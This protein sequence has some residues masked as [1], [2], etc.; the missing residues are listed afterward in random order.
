M[1]I[2]VVEDERKL[3]TD[4][5][6]ALAGA[7]HV[8]EEAG[9]GEHAWF[10]GDTE[11]YDLII[12]DLGLPKLDGV[13]VLKRWRANQRTMPVLV[14]TARD[15]WSEKVEAID[16][17]ADDYL[18]KPFRMEELLARVRA[19]L[20]RQT[21]HSSAMLEVGEI[22][23]DTR[24]SRVTKAGT[25]VDLSPLEYRLLHYLMHH[26]GR[27]VSQIELTEHVYSQD[28]ERESNAIE[29][30]IGRL[31]RKLGAD[32]V[33]TRRGYGYYTGELDEGAP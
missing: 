23:L 8:V 11:D 27:A 31:R 28:F 6:K 2:L 24:H 4:L 30:L 19:L 17:G 29:V 5:A 25:P 32:A 3:A 26:A 21:K 33:K 10:L 15:S 20:R 14:L 18:T 9:N 16:I 7:G 1:R 13:Q 12:L 22:L